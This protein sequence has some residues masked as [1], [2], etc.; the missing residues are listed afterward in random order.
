MLGMNRYAGRVKRG[1]AS[2]CLFLTLSSCSG[3]GFGRDIDALV[4]GYVKAPEEKTR[5]IIVNEIG[6][7]AVPVIMRKF[8]E[9]H[10]P[11]RTMQE[12]IDRGLRLRFLSDGI[13]SSEKQRPRS[14]AVAFQGT[15][16][17]AAIDSIEEALNRPEEQ[18]VAMV[19]LGFIG[20]PA[21]GAIPV[22]TGILESGTADAK[23]RAANSIALIGVTDGRSMQILSDLAQSGT[24]GVRDAARR[25][26]ESLTKPRRQ[27]MIV[28]ALPGDYER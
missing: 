10:Q 18:A 21:A 27:Q 1:I 26:L 20:R 2:G 13:I 12:R 16:W 3:A 5:S 4:D 25:A 7:A 6:P 15:A 17:K 11:G 9:V 28:L 14:G 8:R 22:L 23:E 19:L 24:D